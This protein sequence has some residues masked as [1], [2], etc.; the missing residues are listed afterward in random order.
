MAREHKIDGIVANAVV[1]GTVAT[2]ASRDYLDEAE[3]AAAASPE[4]V[5]RVLAF[6]A[7]AASTASTASSS[8][9]TPARPTYG[10]LRWTAGLAPTTRNGSPP[11]TTALGSGASGRS[12]DKSCSHA[13]NARRRAA[14]ASLDRDSRAASDNAAVCVEQRALRHLARD[15]EAHLTIHACERR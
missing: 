5:A 1:L 14:A 7:F 10:R 12:C 13:R 8:I 15:L 4:E 6:L 9:S 11:S 2:E 3:Y